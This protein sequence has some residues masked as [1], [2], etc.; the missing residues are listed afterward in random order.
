MKHVQLFENW[1]KNWGQGT[2][3]DSKEVSFTQW[4]ADLL[5]QWPFIAKDFE[6]AGIDP[7]SLTADN[8][9]DEVAA[10][11]YL[12]NSDRNLYRIGKYISVESFKRP[13]GERITFMS[14]SADISTYGSWY[15]SNSTGT[16]VGNPHPNIDTGR[17]GT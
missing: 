7:Y 12:Y 11:G 13:N 16:V 2:P 8:F 1:S 9:Y 10:K 3:Y 17:E 14:A 5:E 6:D 15:S 4:L